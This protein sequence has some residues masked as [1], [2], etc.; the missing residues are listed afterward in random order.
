MVTRGAAS[1]SVFL[2]VLWTGVGAGVA[3]RA[4]SEPLA[5]V[6]PAKTL[7]RVA[8]RERGPLSAQ[9]RGSLVLVAS[10]PGGFALVS[11]QSQQ[12]EPL[13]PRPDGTDGRVLEAPAWWTQPWL[14]WV[15]AIAAGGLALALGWIASLR[16]QAA[17]STR[18]IA[19]RLRAEEALREQYEAVFDNASDMIYAHDLDGRVTSLNR[20]G[21]RMTGY[22][23]E[24]SAVLTFW[25][26]LAPDDVASVREQLAAAVAQHATAI[27]R[28][29]LRT[30]EGRDLPIEIHAR[31]VFAAGAATAIEGIARDLT[32][33]E[34]FESEVREAQKMEAVGRLAAGVA[35]DFNNLLTVILAYGD[36][37]AGRLPQEGDE[38]RAIVAI[39]QAGSRAASLTAQMLAFGRRQF[40][41]PTV[42]DL[43]EVVGA[44]E[45]LVDRVL[46]DEIVLQI[47]SAERP[48]PVL[49]DRAQL[50][51]VVIN[52]VINARDAMPAGGRLQLST[53]VWRVTDEESASGSQHAALTPGE[54][55]RLVVSDTGT[56]IPADVQR[57]VFEPFY[58]TT[59]GTG[60]GLAI[61]HGFVKQSGGHIILRSA[62]GDGA[63][64]ELLFPLVRE[65]SAATPAADS[66][67]QAVVLVAEDDTPVRR[68]MVESLTQRGFTVIEASDGEQ[69]REAVNRHEGPIDLLLTDL[70]MPRLGGVE[71]AR[72][73]AAN[74][75][76]IRVLFMSGYA[77][78]ATVTDGAFGPQSFLQKPFTREA[79]LD[80][81]KE[82][83]A[84]SPPQATDE[85][86]R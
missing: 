38:R 31:P 57:H 25:D 41:A 30:R 22:T 37:L 33:R 66:D 26:F 72:W 79:L 39:Q 54:Y 23:R 6:A 17:R 40:L 9:W 59:L 71:L 18:V 42:V 65:T 46:G 70:R 32:E 58:S 77:A 83:L 11:Q 78:P 8:S 80:R 51:Q 5:P 75:P 1:R 28:A 68:L 62:P 27:V 47:T 34:R 76:G 73:L 55:A 24:Q 29:R 84:A 45:P 86:G 14:F 61:V 2:F 12:I 36:F 44:L 74:R 20:A 82:L 52:L 10:Q 64:F 16:G 7:A 53:S 67:R 15:L 35:H 49:I 3:A 63:S 50:E 69:A 21:E 85:R 13:T 4:P 60:L 43:D 19:E 48:L 56:G 81:I